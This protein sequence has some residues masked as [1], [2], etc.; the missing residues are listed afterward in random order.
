MWKARGTKGLRESVELAISAVE[1]FI[2]RIR[3]RNGF[4][5]VLPQYEGCNVCFW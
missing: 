1:Y 2:D 5:L 3:N 4:R